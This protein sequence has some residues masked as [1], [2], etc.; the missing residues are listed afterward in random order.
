MFN[1]FPICRAINVLP[2]PEKKR[3]SFLIKPFNPR[4]RYGETIFLSNVLFCGTVKPVLSGHPLLSGQYPMS[5]N[6]FL[7]FTLNETFT[8]RTLLLSE[9]GHLKST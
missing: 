8:K 6:L 9:R 7:P 3:I 1:I 4:A 2:V 5:P